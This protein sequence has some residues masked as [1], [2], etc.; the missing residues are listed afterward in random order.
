MKLISAFLLFNLLFLPFALQAEEHTIAKSIIVKSGVLNGFSSF[1]KQTV[2]GLDK[3]LRR[4]RIEGE[5]T[6]AEIEGVSYVLNDAADLEVVA[7]LLANELSDAVDITTL[8]KVDD[9]YNSPLAK[10]VEQAKAALHTQ[11]GKKE[12]AYF[13]KE[14]RRTPPNPD[15]QQKINDIL[16]SSLKV[17]FVSTRLVHQNLLVRL[18]HQYS[19]D[20]QQKALCSGLMEPDT[21]IRDNIINYRGDHEQETTIQNLS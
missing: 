4:V 6:A 17:E 11:R 8:T 19:D 7:D 16:Y 13:L 10:K 12:I 18:V 15:R 14:R 5:L 20:D 2:R 9:W 1:S 21:L 3:L